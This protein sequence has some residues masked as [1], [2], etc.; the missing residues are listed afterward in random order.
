[1]SN[2]DSPDH[3]FA[4]CLLEARR[5][6][7]K[8]S[9]DDLV[10]EPKTLSEVY[11]VHQAVARA[12][13]SVGAFKTSRL[14][15]EA[16]IIAPIFEHNV[17]AS[18]IAL[19]APDSGIIGVELEV[20]FRVIAAPPSASSSASSADFEQQLRECVEPVCALEIVD[21]RL[22]DP[23]AAAPMTKL[24][25]NQINA[26]LVTGGSVADWQNLDLANMTATFR[27]GDKTV[28]D[29]PASVPGGD[30]FVTL[31]GA[32]RLIEEIWGGLRPGQVVITGALNGVFMAE[33]GTKV[34][35]QIQGLGEVSA[36]FSP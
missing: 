5:S 9:A 22:A 29:G 23:D 15:G 36:E 6:G 11:E 32:A 27:V 21:A 4:S 13:G 3:P 18:P 16:Q 35:G 26:G 14:P 1:M 33:R 2:T 24:A 34:W 12:I 10:D 31:C 30:A 28:F 19:A 20:G 17:H 7:V 25:D 8:I